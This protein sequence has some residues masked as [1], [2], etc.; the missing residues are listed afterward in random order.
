M[1]VL[2]LGQLIDLSNFNFVFSYLGS[3]NDKFAGY[4]ERSD[5][6]FS[7]Y[8]MEDKYVRNPI[9]LGFEACG[10]VSL[11]YLGYNVIKRYYDNNTTI[12][13]IYNMY[14]IG[15]IILNT[16]RTLELLNRTGLFLQSFYFLPLALILYFRKKIKNLPYYKISV[17][18]LIWWSY[19]YLKYLFFF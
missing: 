8:G 14:I 9:I 15:A 11:I 4:Y 12:M 10:N 13:S 18:F 1:A 7:S 3:I 16:F 5:Q 2:V 17:L 19:D 6:W